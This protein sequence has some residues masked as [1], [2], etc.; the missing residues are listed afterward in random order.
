MRELLLVEQCAVHW[1]VVGRCG[2]LRLSRQTEWDWLRPKIHMVLCIC[3]EY[4]LLTHIQ[5]YY[6]GQRCQID[7]IFSYTSPASGLL[8]VL[9]YCVQ[10]LFGLIVVELLSCHVCWKPPDVTVNSPCH[11]VHLACKERK[12]CGV[13]VSFSVNMHLNIHYVLILL[14]LYYCFHH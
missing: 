2:R 3:T 13:P 1:P 11:G 5:K 9:I 14:W 6:A 12:A 10:L 4:F 8:R 7:C